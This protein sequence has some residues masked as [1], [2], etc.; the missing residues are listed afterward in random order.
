MKNNNIK[1]SIGM[2]VFNDKQFLSKALDSILAQ[3]FTNFELIIS[4]DG[5]TD[6]SETICLEYAKKDN[7][8][9]YIRQKTNLGISRNMNFLLSKSKSE[10]FMWV[11]D[12]D[13]W[14]NDFIEKLLQKLIK[15]PR[16]IVAFAPYTCID[17]NDDIINKKHVVIES[18]NEN[19]AYL[20]LR[21]FIS[22]MSDGFGYGLFRRDMI[23]DVKFPVWWGIN[24]KTAYNNIYPTL[25][26]Y[27]SKGEYEF[28]NKK[29][30]WFNRLKNKKNIH[31]RL[32]YSD[33][34]TK[35]YLAF[36]L[37][38]FNLA[39]ISILNVHKGSRKIGLTFKIMPHIFYSL[40]F[41]RIRNIR[42]KRI[43]FNEKDVE[44]FI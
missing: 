15:N 6:G 16:A 44:I 34:F 18:F 33:N 22:N 42:K 28:Y 1:V 14:A 27:L 11:A 17:E 7:R 32:P 37:R 41:V 24:K 31:H 25:F 43:K 30:L 8:I 19:T 20:R 9:K 21:K 3:T 23:K 35:S 38:K 29:I 4:D 26:F 10:F 40:F 12:D 13:L 39:Y 2:P 36:V 5:S